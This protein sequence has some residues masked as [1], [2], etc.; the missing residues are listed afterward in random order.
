MNSE[1]AKLQ[2]FNSFCQTQSSLK[3]KIA[4]LTF[5]KVKFPVWIEALILIFEYLQLISQSILIS[6]FA[7]ED[8]KHDKAFPNLIFY[9]LK[10]INPIYLLAEESSDSIKSAILII[11]TCGTFLKIL[12]FANVIYVSIA[13]K[14]MSPWLLT[15]W[16]WIFKLQT[17]I[18]YFVFTSFWV[19]VMVEAQD[20]DFRLSGM[21]KASL[22]P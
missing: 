17:R 11:L 16:R 7:Y 20:R 19:H 14:N 5:Y 13:K 8:S 12:L 1:N 10:L 4:L 9:L 6:P 18:I 15:I 21:S 22:T 2:T 3:T